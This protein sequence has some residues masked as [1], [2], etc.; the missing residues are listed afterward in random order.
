MGYI[1]KALEKGYSEHPGL[2]AGLMTCL[3]FSFFLDSAGVAF[4][5]VLSTGSHVRIQIHATCCC[6]PRCT[7]ETSGSEKS[8]LWRCKLGAGYSSDIP[9][10]SKKAS[11]SR[12]AA[13]CIHSR[14][15]PDSVHRT[16]DGLWAMPPNTGWVPVK[17]CRLQDWERLKK[18]VRIHK[19]GDVCPNGVP[20]LVEGGDNEDDSDSE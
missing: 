6:I 7:P 16:T 9:E 20:A 11:Y 12:S 10:H 2:H 15:T 8:M 3:R 13:T 18:Y 17:A 1:R 4:C 14:G 5:L 19:Q